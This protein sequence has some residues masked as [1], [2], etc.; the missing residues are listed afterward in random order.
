MLSAGSASAMLDDMGRIAGNDSEYTG[1]R[2]FGRADYFKI[3]V[4]GFAI[5]ALWN[6]IHGL[7]LP[8]RVL[9]FATGPDKFLWIAV[10]TLSGYIL[11]MVIQPIAGVI[12]DRSGFGWGRRRPFVLIGALL[13]IIFIFGMGFAGSL[14][15][16]LIFYCLLQVGSNVA[17]GPWQG[18]IPD[19][20][21]EEK[22][23]RASG[24]KNLL[25]LVGGFALIK[26]I[27][28]LMSERYAGDDGSRLWLALGVL[29]IVML[30]AMIITMLTVRE[31]PGQGGFKL[32]P[33]STML[34]SF[35]IDTKAQPGFILFLVSRFLFL[36]PLL[37][38]RNYGLFFFQDVADVPDPGATMANL[39]LVIGVCMLAVVYPAGR[40][41][42]RIGRRPIAVASG[43]IG[44]L[45]IVSLF[46]L[47][48]YALIIL[49]S[50]LLGIS[51][52]G[53]LSANW[54]LATDLAGNG[55]EAR[56]LGLVN[57][58]TAGSGALVALLGL[59]IYLL[60]VD[61]PGLGYKVMLLTCFFLF[62]ISTLL[63]LKIKM[64]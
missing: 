39:I 53:F 19:L 5:S 7:I 57:L 51:Y 20:V 21:P 1:A 56:H 46:F 23:G 52:G 27:G 28:D 24:V 38:F 6:S 29:A 40:L 2:G 49:G 62:I 15:A 55:E 61:I 45:A 35:R 25:E 60:E 26:L 34:Q 44:A 54:A 32:P 3:G 9:D 18:L 8:L 4:L 33:L 30:A 37:V 50:C 63:L 43:I 58:A 47:Q 10:L 14:A 12:S 59:V 17:Q 48:Y 42:D 64:R 31:R 16:I 11:A 22:R 13:A 36:T 41:S